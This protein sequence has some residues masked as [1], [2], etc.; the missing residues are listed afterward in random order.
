MN[1]H[2]GNYMAYSLNCSSLSPHLHGHEG[3]R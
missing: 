1:A 2:M 3:D